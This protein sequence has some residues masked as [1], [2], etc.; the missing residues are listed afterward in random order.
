V[1][2]FLRVR[3]HPPVFDDAQ[4]T[5]SI[6]CRHDGNFLFQSYRYGIVARDR[7]IDQLLLYHFP[8]ARLVCGDLR[9]GGEF[10]GWNVGRIP[11]T[12]DG[13]P[14]EGGMMDWVV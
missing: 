2:N 14:E 7:S 3:R 12:S 6:W 10:D 5:E 1:K 13:S 4:L 9:V 11:C 8:V